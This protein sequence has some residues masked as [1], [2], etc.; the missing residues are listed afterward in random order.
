M[1]LK[2]FLKLKK[3]LK[4]LSFGQ[5]FFKNPKT[6]K[7][8]KEPKNPQKPKK[9]Q[10]NPKKNPKKTQKTQKNP[11][12]W[13]KKTKKRVF[14]NP[15]PAAVARL[16]G[17]PAALPLTCS[18]LRACSGRRT[19]RSGRSTPPTIKDICRKGLAKINS[20]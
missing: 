13:L 7:S 4:S 3:T 8:P 11:L 19:R 12:G 14:S 18:G 10:K 20:V 6:Q 16:S 15:A 17:A 2:V 5:I 9:N 1:H